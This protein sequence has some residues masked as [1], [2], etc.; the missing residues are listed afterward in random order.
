MDKL[1]KQRQK[2]QGRLLRA[3]RNQQGFTLWEILVGLLILVVALASMWVWCCYE[4]SDAIRVVT[5]PSGESGVLVDAASGSPPWNDKDFLGRPGTNISLNADVTGIG[6][7]IAFAH[8]RRPTLKENVDWIAGATTV[9]MCLEHEITIPIDIWIL[10]GPYNPADE[11]PFAQPNHARLSAYDTNELIWKPE[12]TGLVL[13]INIHDVTADPDAGTFLHFTCLNHAITTV[14]DDRGEESPNTNNI[15]HKIGY[16]PNRINVYVVETADDGVATGVHCGST[17]INQDW[18]VIALGYLFD[19]HLLAHEIG[20]ALSLGHVND[21]LNG[22]VLPGF[23]ENNVMHDSTIS[24]R[25]LSEGQT[26]RQVIDLNSAIERIYHMRQP[27]T[28][29]RGA[30]DCP[31]FLSDDTA[32][33]RYNIC[34]T[35]GRRLWAD[36]GLGPGP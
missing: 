5:G 34:P 18:G 19:T 25:F 21:R 12:A 24:R 15:Q 14:Y 4:W 20:H 13:D 8:G 16:T 17:G 35:L 3:S 10:K 23:D 6:E 27:L 22:T 1:P 11:T 26:F 9:D 32:H 29:A 28:P 2:E 33:A 30:L 31:A 36:G 7:I